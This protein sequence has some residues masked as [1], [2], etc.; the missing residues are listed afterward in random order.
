MN[1]HTKISELCSI[2]GQLK[3]F[4]DNSRSR[5]SIDSVFTAGDWSEDV[6][7]ELARLTSLDLFPDSDLFRLKIDEDFIKI[8][9]FVS[10]GSPA[11]SE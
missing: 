1:L 8:S 9:D 6:G 4:A 2:L 11:V 10:E 3:R 5:E 7:R